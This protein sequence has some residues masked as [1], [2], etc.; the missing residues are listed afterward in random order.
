MVIGVLNIKNDIE[1]KKILLIVMALVAL[2]SCGSNKDEVALVQQIDEQ[3]LEQEA[4]DYAFN[5]FVVK[6]KFL[7]EVYLANKEKGYTQNDF[8]SC[9]GADLFE[10][11]MNN[12]DLEKAF[13][14]NSDEFLDVMTTKYKCQYKKQVM[15]YAYEQ[16][17]KIINA[18]EQ[19]DTNTP[20]DK[21]ITIKF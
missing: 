12:Y 20:K 17:L 16:N 19:I 15:E 11:N 8:K 10:I 21:K 2:T 13:V 1:M 4:S 5:E 3:K 9:F 18:V 6:Y 14:T 7:Q